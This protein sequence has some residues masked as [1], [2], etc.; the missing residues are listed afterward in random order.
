[1]AR[2]ENKVVVNN[3]VG[4]LV[5]DCTELNNPPNTTIDEDNCDLDR[6]GSRKRRLGIDFEDGFEPSQESW[7][8]DTWPDLYLKTF[9]WRSVAEDGTLNFLV[10][11]AGN[12]LMFYDMNSDT[13]SSNELPFS[14]NLDDFRTAGYYSTEQFGVQVAAGKGALFVVGEAIEPFYIQYDPSTNTITTTQLDIKIR[15]LKRQDYTLGLTEEPVTISN[16]Q[17]YDLYNQ[18]WSAPTN[19]PLGADGYQFTTNVLDHFRAAQGFYPSLSKSW[20]V[21]KIINIKYGVNM[22]DGGSWKTAYVGNTL[23][24]LGSYI[25]EAFNQD[26]SAASGIAGIPLVI[27][28]SRPTAVAFAAGRVFFGFKNKIYFSQVILDDYTVAGNCYQVADPTAEKINDL[29]AT[30]GGVVQIIDGGTIFAFITFENSIFTFCSNGVW[31]LGGSSIGSGFAA[32]DFSV[33]KVTETAAL[34]PRSVISVLGT[35][36][37][38]AKDG[39]YTIVGDPAKQGYSAQNILLE[40]LQL[41]YNAIPP[42]SKLYATGTY[43]HLKKTITWIYNSQGDPIGGNNFVCDKVL[44]YDTLLHA[45]YPY[46]LSSVTNGNSPVVVDVFSALDVIATSTSDTVIDENGYTVIDELGDIVT[47]DETTLGNSANTT[48]L[49]KF[50]TFYLS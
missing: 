41:Y 44:N 43:D 22:F 31:A 20:W 40:K 36:Y 37:W 1:M 48:S 38:W 7:D 50:Y 18:G 8:Q 26:R 25:L 30:D 24:P 9:V 42:L 6:R 35:P 28:S 12:T 4:G 39:I 32:T 46:T 21:G 45:F 14:V 17:R 29:V 23:A 13:I 16:M 15:D 2:T 19:V 5:S 3:F 47:V 49:L 34:S 27:E 11:Q 10:A 33:Y